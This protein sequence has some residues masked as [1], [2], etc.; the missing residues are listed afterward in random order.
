MFE[1]G[2]LSATLVSATLVSATLVSATFAISGFIVLGAM[3]AGIAERS[4]EHLGEVE[5]EVSCMPCHGIDGRGDGV[6]AKGLKH[7]PADLTRIAKANGGR[8]PADRITGII[9][10]RAVTAAHGE[11]DMPAWGERYSRPYGKE[12]RS[13]MESRVRRQIRALVD[14]LRTIQER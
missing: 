4:D 7:P 13:Q 9:D 6:L 1:R 3:T 2:R 10:G 8:F 14:Y 12:T 5:Y 11:R